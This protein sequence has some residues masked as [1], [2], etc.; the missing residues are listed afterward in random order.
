MNENYPVFEKWYRIL[1]WI[2]DMCEKE[3]HC[4]MITSES[5]IQSVQ[6]VFGLLRQYNTLK[7]RKK[8]LGQI[9]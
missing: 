7:L 9:S 6:S 2:M 4:E 8:L 3:Y 5:Y 1:S